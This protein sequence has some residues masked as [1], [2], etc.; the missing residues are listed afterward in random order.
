M[1]I[2]VN[3]LVRVG[4]WT[5]FTARSQ[6]SYVFREKDQIVVSQNSSLRMEKEVS[7]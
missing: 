3:Q 7:F 5:L 1:Q 6:H 4:A 2:P